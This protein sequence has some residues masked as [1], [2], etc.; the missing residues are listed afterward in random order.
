LIP[1]LLT[2]T[3]MR[4]RAARTCVTSAWHFLPARDV[5]GHGPGAFGIH[6]RHLHMGALAGEPSADGRTDPASAARHQRQFAL[7]SAHRLLLPDVA[8]TAGSAMRPMGMSLTVAAMP[9]SCAKPSAIPVRTQPGATATETIREIDERGT[10]KRA[11]G[12][13]QHQ[14]GAR[15]LTV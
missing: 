5:C 15:K 3:S 14:S 6:G 4:L 11:F 10:V 12:K 1:A 7:K 8:A 13:A 2:S 9:C